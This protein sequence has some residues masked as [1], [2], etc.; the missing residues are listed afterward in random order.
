MALYRGKHRKQ[1]ATARGIAKVAVAGAI[2]GAPLAIA[3]APA[4]AAG[5]GVNWDAIAQCE[6]S[7]NWAANTGNGF[8]G[9]LQFTMS[10]WHAFGGSGNPQDA[11]R[12]QQIAVAERVLA[13]QGIG[14]WPVCG[15]KA[16]S[17]VNY[18]PA[19]KAP[20]KKAAPAE[21]TVKQAPKPKKAAPAPAPAPAQQAPA[22]NTA[23]GDYTVQA[24]DT[25]SGIADK[26]GVSGGW[27]ELYQK[28]QGSISNPNLI[29]VGQVIATK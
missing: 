2:V 26:L 16:G 27:Q 3:A 23:G 11:S 17:T 7:G 13:G 10:T 21:D 18:T 1:S 6:S 20:A 29:F 22:R 24:G 25:L 28:N 9:G 4:Q 8:Y 5:S 19:T 15:A 12:E 14:A